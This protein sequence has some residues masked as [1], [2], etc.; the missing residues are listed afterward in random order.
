M[1]NYTLI[2]VMPTTRPLFGRSLSKASI[3]TISASPEINNKRKKLLLLLLKRMSDGNMLKRYR[4][5]RV[6]FPTNLIYEHLSQ[7]PN[8]HCTIM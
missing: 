4:N 7:V 3:D 1:K 6:I 8:I 5:S 2:N